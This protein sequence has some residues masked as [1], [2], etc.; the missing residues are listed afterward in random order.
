MSEN[1]FTAELKRL[2]KNIKE[3]LARE[4]PTNTITIDYFLLS[5]IDDEKC[6]ANQMMDT[7]M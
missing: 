1:R 7:V 3:N 2:F 4:Y 6:V 5:V